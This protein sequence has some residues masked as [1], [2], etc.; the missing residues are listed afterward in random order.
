MSNPEQAGVGPPEGFEELLRLRSEYGGAAKIP[1]EELDTIGYA[2]HDDGIVAPIGFE[3]KTA[4]S[5]DEKN[6]RKPFESFSVTLDGYRAPRYIDVGLMRNVKKRLGEAERYIK[7][8]GDIDLSQ[9]MPDI[10]NSPLSVLLAPDASEPVR[11][12]QQACVEFMESHRLANWPQRYRYGEPDIDI[13]RDAI[14]YH[15]DSADYQEQVSYEDGEWP[16]SFA[17]SLSSDIENK[18]GVLTDIDEL[19]QQYDYYIGMSQPLL[20]DEVDRDN[21]DIT[22][23]IDTHDFRELISMYFESNLEPRDGESRS[24]LEARDQLLEYKTRPELNQYFDELEQAGVDTVGKQV[25]HILGKALD[26]MLPDTLDEGMSYVQATMEFSG[27]RDAVDFLREVQ[28]S[29]RERARQAHREAKQAYKAIDP[30]N[31]E[32]KRA[33]GMMVNETK[34]AIKQAGRELDGLASVFGR[35]Y[36]ISRR[37]NKYFDDIQETLHGGSREK[38]ELV[39]V[40]DVDKELDKDPGK[41]SGDCTEGVPLPFLDSGNRLFNVKVFSNGEHA[42]NI[43]LLEGN[44]EEGEPYVWHF[45]AI[46]VPMYMDWSSAAKN[47]LNGFIEEAQKKGVRAITINDRPELVSNYDYISSAFLDIAR[48]DTGGSGDVER[49]VRA[50]APPKIDEG[51]GQNDSSNMQLHHS[52]TL[53]RLY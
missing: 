12:Y 26:R 38:V 40:S 31:T 18:R 1:E 17:A 43:Y 25:M 39:F 22:F 5:L 37:I 20:D 19:F 21:D 8:G 27:T 45:D 34:K 14:Q 7:L 9:E 23:L 13:L 3:F 24:E 33:A 32:E 42:G 49:A 52:G 51:D 16:G 35:P 30:S 53:R 28:D 6:A 47:I 4:R 2:R 50:A 36:E 44:D 41:V 10:H 46:Q 11:L 48:D 29:E 15:N